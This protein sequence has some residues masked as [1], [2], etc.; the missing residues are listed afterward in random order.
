MSVQ[1]ANAEVYKVANTSG[2]SFVIIDKK[3]ADLHIQISQVDFWEQSLY[4]HCILLFW[5]TLDTHTFR[6]CTGPHF[7][8]A[9]ASNDW[10]VL[11]RT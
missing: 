6:K 9:D 5:Q 10:L 11:A 3:D 7:E 1:K 8:L 2:Q 4:Q